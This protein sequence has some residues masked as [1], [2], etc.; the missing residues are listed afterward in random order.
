MFIHNISDN[1]H[2]NTHQQITERH[3]F[4]LLEDLH[5]PRHESD[6]LRMEM[7]MQEF[8]VT[9]SGKLGDW[10]QKNYSTEIHPVN[11]INGTINGTMLMIILSSCM[12]YTSGTT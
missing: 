7:H 10:M 12:C 2:K 11:L 9:S 1:H 3:K 5:P 6:N 8:S 4:E